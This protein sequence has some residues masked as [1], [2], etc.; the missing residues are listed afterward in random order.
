MV[1]PYLAAQSWNYWLLSTTTLSL[2]FTLH[3]SGDLSTF[4]TL[5]STTFPTAPCSIWTFVSAYA[6]VSCSC[7]C[8]DHHLEPT[9]STLNTS[10]AF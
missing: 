8:L 7:S 2:H 9:T 6:T 10:P 3:F 5:E 4:R 1:N